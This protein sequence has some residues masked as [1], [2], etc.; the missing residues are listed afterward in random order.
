MNEIPS[1]WKLIDEWDNNLIFE[2]SDN[3]FCVNVTFTEECAFPYSIDFNQLNGTFTIIGFE[4]GAYTS[5]AISKDEAIGK[6]IEMMLFIDKF[7]V[8]QSF[9]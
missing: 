2:N 5:N 9:R 4:N 8:S 1:D 7:T 3:S 6:A